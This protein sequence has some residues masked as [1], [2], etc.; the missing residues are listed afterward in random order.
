MLRLRLRLRL[1][2]ERPSRR[3]VRQGLF[4]GGEELQ[5]LE[6]LANRA[7]SSTD[8]SRRSA[9]ERQKDALQIL[10]RQCVCVSRA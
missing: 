4:V 6:L 1:S 8:H 7:A 5:Q 3:A 2:E 9:A 10:K